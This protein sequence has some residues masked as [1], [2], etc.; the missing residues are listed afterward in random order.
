MREHTFVRRDEIDAQRMIQILESGGWTITV[1]L[2]Q[3]GEWWKVKACL[4]RE[5]PESYWW[6]A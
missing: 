6:E 3:E 1:P 4:T 2:H 5:L